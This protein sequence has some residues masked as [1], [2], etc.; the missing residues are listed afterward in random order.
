MA[1][2][3]NYDGINLEKD[4][5]LAVVSAQDDPDTERHTGNFCEKLQVT[6]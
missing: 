4:T 1:G 6:A 3:G 5:C 2:Y